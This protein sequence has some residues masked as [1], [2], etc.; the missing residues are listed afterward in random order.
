M[1]LQRAGMIT[2]L[3]M[4]LEAPHANPLGRTLHAFMPLQTPMRQ[5][6]VAHSLSGSW[7]TGTGRH[8]PSMA[9]VLAI[10]HAWHDPRQAASQQTPSVQL[11][12]WHTSP[13]IHGWPIGNSGIMSTGGGA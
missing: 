3:P 8:N 13:A 9:P 2:V 12:L 5:G 11:P 10:T 1:P 6:S 7:L 4:Q